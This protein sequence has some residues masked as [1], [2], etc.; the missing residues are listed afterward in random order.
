MDEECLRLTEILTTSAA[1]ANYQGCADVGPEQ[2]LHAVA[3]LQG[4][5]S[6]EDLGRPVS[7]L[8]PRGP[9]S[10]GAAPAVRDLATRWF[11]LLGSDVN[12]V[13]TPEQLEAFVAELRALLPPDTS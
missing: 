10:G 2:V 4:A 7:P 5:E 8:V 9:G 11:A 6:I 13:M 1:V 3:I 12:A